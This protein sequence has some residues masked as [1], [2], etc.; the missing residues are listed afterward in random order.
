MTIAAD[1]A[2]RP[3]AP[4]PGMQ[5]VALWCFMCERCEHV[6][7][8]RVYR[9]PKVCPRCKSPYWD[10]ATSR[11][12]SRGTAMNADNAYGEPML[13]MEPVQVRDD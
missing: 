13:M 2:A 9:A 12:R 3:D 4:L 10:R 8:P 5:R 11:A 7:L 6:W 1:G